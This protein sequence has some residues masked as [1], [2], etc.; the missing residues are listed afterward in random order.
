VV[1]TENDAEMALALGQD[2]A[3]PDGAAPAAT[4]DAA[5]QPEPPPPAPGEHLA[6]PQGAVR[7]PL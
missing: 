6:Q 5:P 3:A 2:G 7:N 4:P 1:E